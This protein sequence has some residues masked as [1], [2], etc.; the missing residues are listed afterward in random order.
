MGYFS[1]QFSISFTSDGAGSFEEDSKSCSKCNHNSIRKQFNIYGTL[2]YNVV[3]IKNQELFVNYNPLYKIYN[4]LK[5]PKIH[6]NVYSSL[7]VQLLLSSQE[8]TGIVITSLSTTL[9]PS[10]VMAIEMR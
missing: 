2:Q 3:R 7:E 10:A 8:D 1:N 4:T 9:H 5:I 6:R